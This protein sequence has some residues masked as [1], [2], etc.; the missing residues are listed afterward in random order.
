MIRVLWL[1][2]VSGKS[3]QWARPDTRKLRNEMSEENKVMKTPGFYRLC[4]LDV[5]AGCSVAET[6]SKQERSEKTYI[7]HN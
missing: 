3:G 6:P 1:D 2:L 7:F 5:P 4:F